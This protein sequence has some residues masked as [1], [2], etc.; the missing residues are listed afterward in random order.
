MKI[1]ILGPAYPF[2]GGLAVYNE[3]LANALLDAGHE[4]TIYTFTLQ[5]PSFLFPGKSQYSTEPAPKRLK[6]VRV[7]N[8]VNPFNWF[9]VGKKIRESQPDIIIA[10]FWLPFMGPCF[11]T[12]LRRVKKNGITKALTIIDNIIPHE[13]RPGD[14]WFTQYFVNAVDGLIA[15]SDSVFK[16]IDLFNKKGKPKLLSPHPLYDNFGAPIARNKAIQDLGLDPNDKILLFFGLIRDYKGLDILIKAFADSRFRDA[17]YKLIIA[18]EYY[19]DKSV[20]TDLI[21]SYNLNDDVVQVDQFIPDSMVATY[22][23]AAD[24]VVQP[25]KSATQSGV[26][27]IAYHFNKPMIVTNVGGLQEMCP[28]GEVGYVVSPEPKEIANAIIK[29]FSDTD[30]E[31]MVKNIVEEKKKYSWEILVENLLKLKEKV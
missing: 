17:G 2:R 12:V 6:I 31:M 27:Q 15:M 24:L 25:Y 28:H 9:A 3:R 16:D 13:K 11:G 26:T 18:G 14:K 5:Y 7:L 29:Y 19:S 21:D 22:F 10:K 8:S 1:A 23:S 20:Y 30:I 4:V